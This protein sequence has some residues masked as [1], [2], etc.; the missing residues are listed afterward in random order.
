MP[1]CH[2]HDITITKESPEYWVDYAED[3][4]R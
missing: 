2:P 3:G 1:E 4:K